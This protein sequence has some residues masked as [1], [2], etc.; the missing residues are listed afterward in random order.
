MPKRKRNGS[1]DDSGENSDSECPINGGD[2]TDDSKDAIDVF[3][4]CN[5]TKDQDHKKLCV[6]FEPRVEI[7]RMSE[8]TVDSMLA[9][10]SR[11]NYTGIKVKEPSSTQ[12]TESNFAQ[13]SESGDNVG[14]H[15]DALNQESWSV[16]ESQSRPLT[17]KKEPVVLKGPLKGILVNVNC[18]SIN[19]HRMSEAGECIEQSQRFKPSV[20]DRS[21]MESFVESLSDKE[22]ENDS[23]FESENASTTDLVDDFSDAQGD[24]SRKPSEA[25]STDR[26]ISKPNASESGNF[27]H[28]V[29]LQIYKLCNV[30]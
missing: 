26:G 12:D 28:C 8:S 10:A 5:K 21:S 13:T 22:I 14:S 24:M 27:I 9:H 18:I 30:L 11:S 1:S 17:P 19:R 3:N 20:Q 15:S 25:L 16:S 7:T 23:V 2:M 4:P 6:S 29:K